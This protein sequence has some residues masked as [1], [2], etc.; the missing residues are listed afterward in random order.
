[1]PGYNPTNLGFN[2]A[3]AQAVLMKSASDAFVNTVINGGS[4]S[5]NLGNALAGQASNIG[6]AVGFKSVGG[7]A[8]GKY[9]DGSI[10]KVLAHAL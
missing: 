2:M 8:L 7:W 10:Q 5:D 4:Y 9:D 1:M 3:S 6:M